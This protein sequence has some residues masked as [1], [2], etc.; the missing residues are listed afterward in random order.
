ML[1][2]LLSILHLSAYHLLIL[3]FATISFYNFAV[4]LVRKP[5]YTGLSLNSFNKHLPLCTPERAADMS[6]ILLYIIFN[7]IASSYL[8]STKCLGD[9]GLLMVL[10]YC[11]QISFKAHSPSTGPLTTLY[12]TLRHKNIVSLQMPDLLRPAAQRGTHPTVFQQNRK[13]HLVLHQMKTCPW[14]ASKRYAKS[15][16]TACMSMVVK[17]VLFWPVTQNNCRSLYGAVGGFP[18]L[19]TASPIALPRLPLPHGPGCARTRAGIAA[20]GQCGA[21]T[22]DTS[23]QLT[24]TW[25][26]AQDHAIA[27]APPAWVV[28]RIR[29]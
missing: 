26:K 11:L 1:I 15:Y 8:T 29:L 16:E 12:E 7:S 5:R 22:E 24:L 14:W 3:L 4:C 10:C 27:A 23:H 6:N 13:T 20:W 19:C 18:R 9:Y 2:F 28:L 17:D 25:R 21:P